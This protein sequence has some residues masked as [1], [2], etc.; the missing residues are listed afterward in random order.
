MTKKAGVRNYTEKEIEALRKKFEHYVKTDSY[1]RPCRF[2][3]DNF[4]SE[5]VINKPEFEELI[6]IARLKKE[7]VLEEKGLSGEFNAAMSIFGL[8]QC[9]WSDKLETTN[10]H[11]V[12]GIQIVT[13]SPD[14]YRNQR[15]EDDGR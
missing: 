14:E 2:C 3:A 9:G 13:L 8:K 10:K 7:A 5:S 1:P 4:I 11:E 12:S 6:K 15:M